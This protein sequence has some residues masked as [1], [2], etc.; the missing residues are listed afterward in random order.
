MSAFDGF[1]A[2]GCS[3][4]ELMTQGLGFGVTAGTSFG[5]L[6]T[7]LLNVTLEKGWRHGL[8]IVLS[9][10][11]T[12][13]PIVLLAVLVLNQLPPQALTV[14]QIIGGFVVLYLALRTFLQLRRTPPAALKA[15]DPTIAQTPT[16]Q[17]LLKGMAVNLTNPAP[18]LFWGTF[19]GPLLMQGLAESPL[20]AIA[21]LLSFYVPF[22]GL[23][24]AFMIAFDRMRALP[25]SIVRG[26][27]YVSVAIL[28]V[29]GVLLIVNGV[30]ALQTPIV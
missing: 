15:T 14:L 2:L 28:C 18:Y 19:M 25:A 6:H 11:I 4:L 26:L 17:T 27:S 9:P 23:M 30:S 1:A 21:F 29:L 3:M 12:D 8:W 16:Y 5:P 20:N 24:T 13:V 7:I 22:L 10:L